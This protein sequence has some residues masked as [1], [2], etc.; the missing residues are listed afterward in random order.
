[1]ISQSTTDKFVF[2]L[3]ISTSKS[4]GVNSNGI[5]AQERDLNIFLQG[6]AQPEVVGKFI[7][8][9][10]GGNN[11]RP[12]L[13]AA[14]KL[15]RKTNSSLVVSN[16]SR[17]SRDV[18]FVAKL[19]KDKNLKI[20]VANI[21]N[22]DNFTIHLFAALAMQERKFIS[23]RTK[24]AMAASKEKYGTVYGNPRIKE[25]NSRQKRRAR[26]FNDA[27]S[28]VICPLR[29]KGMS[30]KDIATTL[31]EMGMKSTRGKDFHSMSVKRIYD[32]S[33]VKC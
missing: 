2:Y 32:R 27:V 22:A 3:R 21:P 29:D 26:T 30:Y 10:S 11:E 4:G 8:V 15:C 13:Q 12:E 18:E 28:P 19:L 31:N 14:I 16:V 33:E 23:Q 20:R 7:E 6:Q 25:L 1:M 17:L 5:A 24:A 9:M